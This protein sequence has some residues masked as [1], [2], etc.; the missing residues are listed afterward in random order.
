MHGCVK[1]AWAKALAAI[2]VA[3][4]VAGMPAWALAET[5][6][7][8]FA[9]IG[10]GGAAWIA[11]ETVEVERG[12]TATQLTLSECEKADITCDYVESSWGNYFNG[13]AKDGGEILGWDAST[14]AY[15][16]LFVD[17]E[18]SMV[19]A[20][21]VVIDEPTSV[22]WAYTAGSKVPAIVAVATNTQTS[23]PDVAATWPDYLGASW[24]ATDSTPFSAGDAAWRAQLADPDEWWTYLSDPV[25]VG[26]KLWLAHGDELLVVD[27][28]SGQTEKVV[29][30]N[31]ETDSACRLAYADGYV[32]VPLSGGSVQAV[33]ATTYET[34]WV[35]DDVASGAQSLSPVTVA[36]GVAYVAT[37]TAGWSGPAT[38]GVLRAIDV[39]TGAVLWSADNTRGAGYYWAGLCADG[40][41]GLIGDDY[42]TLAAVDLESGT[43]VAT[44]D[45]GSAVRSTPVL[46]GGAAYVTTTDGV[47]HKVSVG[48]DGSLSEAGRVQFASSS[49]GT[50][51]VANGL[52]VVGGAVSGETGWHGRL[53]AIDPA[54]MTISKSF[55]ATDDGSALP[56]DVK[57]M[58]LVSGTHVWFTSN[59]EPG[60]LYVA[61]LAAGTC[62]AVYT[63]AG[64]AANWCMASVV[65]TSTGMLVYKNDSGYLFCIESAAEKND[66]PKDDNDANNGSQSGA[67]S[68]AQGYV[69]SNSGQAGS[70]T[71]GSGSAAGNA[72]GQ[73]GR[74]AATPVRPAGAAAATTDD[75][76]ADA[77][78]TDAVPEEPAEQTDEPAATA[79]AV[80]DTAIEDA[81]GTFAIWPIVL[82]ALGLALLAGV[83][84]WRRHDGGK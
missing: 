66:V 37:T 36:D 1:R 18:S 11:P 15:W 3:L 25:C 48:A 63:P 7:A 32:L 45:L 74:R 30:L 12:T 35:S 13:F 23:H 70:G 50:C 59:G 77:T 81:S 33:S 65:P 68:D 26:S 58:P 75:A 21:G 44:V 82:I 24:T 38:D 41:Y 51:A 73:G 40:A 20:D 22:T 54:T 69:G 17:G 60:A 52:L 53:A 28:A 27:E 29:A 72:S 67:G 49:T 43:E 55:D 47:L 2:A 78:P 56:G 62:R 6:E 57:S 31:A 80:S 9:M 61:D 79:H 4:F 42:G 46:L 71:S 5:V 19:G 83:F 39:A 14:G 76:E 64:D 34:A 84:I 16:Q 10:P 8:T